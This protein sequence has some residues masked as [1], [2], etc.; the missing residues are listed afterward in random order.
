M[1]FIWSKPCSPSQRNCWFS[2]NLMRAWPYNWHV[3]ERQI[4]ADVIYLVGCPKIE[5]K[6]HP[7]NAVMDGNST[8]A[9]P[10]YAFILKYRRVSCLASIRGVEY[11]CTQRDVSVINT[12]CLSTLSI[13][14]MC[15]TLLWN[16]STTIFNNDWRLN[17]KQVVIIMIVTFSWLNTM[18]FSM[19]AYPTF[20]EKSQ[21]RE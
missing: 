16:S 13:A 15:I 8:S 17:I 2:R 5:I 6:H 11:F 12:F 19:L 4:I 3:P 21:K 9:S 1:I 7:G 18:A 10:S 14:K 20:K